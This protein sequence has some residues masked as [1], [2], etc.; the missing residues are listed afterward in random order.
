MEWIPCEERLP[1]KQ[2]DYLVT[3]PLDNNSA[4][5]GVLHFHKGKF[6]DTDSEWGDVIYDD[7]TAWM[8][9]PKPYTAD[10]KTENCSEK[11]NNCKPQ[12]DDDKKH[13]VFCKWVCEPNVCGRCRNMNLF[14][15][16]IEDEP[17]TEYPRCVIN[18]TPFDECGFC[19]HFNCDTC[20]CEAQSERSE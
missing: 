3:I 8:T 16:A 9:L 4:Y 18:G 14:A 7:V 19:E 11:P 17:K 2:D 6:Y 20:Q 1:N 10:R 15:D 5:V 12:T 13:C